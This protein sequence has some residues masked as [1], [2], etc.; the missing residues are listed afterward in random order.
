MINDETYMDEAISLA[1]KAATISEVPVGAVVVRNGEIIG[2]GYNK[3]ESGKSSLAHAEIEAISE[4][5]SNVGS[6]RLHD[7]ELYVTLEPCP[8]CAGAIINSRIKRII[9][10]AADYKAGAFGSVFNINDFPL[11]HKSTITG[12]VRC[13]ECA[14]LLSNFF[15]KLRQEQKNTDAN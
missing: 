5:C 13:K 12:G 11:N 8:M 2:R 9:F 15:K 1:L 10:G 3:R 4:A 14:D 7:C 6:W